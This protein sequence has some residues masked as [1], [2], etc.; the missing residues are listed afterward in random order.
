MNIS[1]ICI[2]PT[3]EII[4]VIKILKKTGRKLL[5]V[6][7]KKKKFIGTITDGDIR[8]VIL[9]KVRIKDT[10]EKFYNKKPKSIEKKKFSYRSAK[11]MMMKYNIDAIPILD[12]GKVIK[13]IFWKDIIENIENLSNLDC[14]IFAGGEGKR[15]KPFTIVLPK[16]LIPFN[17]KTFLDQIID[18]F[19][20]YKISNFNLILNYKS[21]IIKSY[22]KDSKSKNNYKFLITLQNCLFL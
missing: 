4:K 6:V 13:V 3:T 2:E 14:V 19:S 16:P 9:N 11:N 7:D 10:I 8:K 15:L 22:L 18:K 1:K 12:N 5:L 17:E 21:N 20:F